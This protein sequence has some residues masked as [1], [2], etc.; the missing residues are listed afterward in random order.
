MPRDYYLKYKFTDR[1]GQEVF[2]LYLMPE[3][4][5]VTLPE[6]ERYGELRLDPRPDAVEEEDES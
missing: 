2:D 5:G 6:T 4:M 1:G 3:G